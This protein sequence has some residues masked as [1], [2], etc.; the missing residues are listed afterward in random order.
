MV[1]RVFGQGSNFNVQQRLL[2]GPG[3]RALR[4]WIITS[5][6]L[7]SM[8]WQATIILGWSTLAYLFHH[9]HAPNFL[10]MILEAFAP[11]LAG[12]IIAGVPWFVAGTKGLPPGGI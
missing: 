10:P 1:R 3:Y 11:A 12:L 8:C 4:W 9:V 7:A 5:F 2:H 6:Y